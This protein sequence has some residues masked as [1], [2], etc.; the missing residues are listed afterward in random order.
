MVWA[1]VADALIAHLQQ[2][3]TEHSAANAF[4]K[5]A[6]GGGGTHASA[7]AT[8]GII[9]VKIHGC[10]G[11]CSDQHR[12]NYCLAVPENVKSFAQ[13]SNNAGY[14]VYL[15]ETAFDAC[16]TTRTPRTE[17]LQAGS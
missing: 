12:I 8:I 16:M 4:L 6:I 5:A 9:K 14:I 17:T 13:C 7:Y 2:G 11:W 1:D 10:E 3:G 15:M